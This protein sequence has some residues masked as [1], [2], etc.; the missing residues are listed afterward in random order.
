[1]SILKTILTLV[2]CVTS[3]AIKAQ[4]IN[5]D[6]SQTFSTLNLQ[7]G[8]FQVETGVQRSVLRFSPI[9]SR[10]PG[11]YVSQSSKWDIPNVALRWGLSDFL[12]LRFATQHA[13]I[14][15]TYTHPY[16]SISPMSYPWDFGNPEFGVKFKFLNLEEK[17][18]H[19]S[20]V[21]HVGLPCSE[22]NIGSDKSYF[23]Y[24]LNFSYPIGEK[25]SLAHTFQLSQIDDTEMFKFTAMYSK[26][27]TENTQLFFEFYRDIVSK[28]KG[29]T[30]SYFDLGL[31][32]R[33]TD[34]L[35]LDW[36]YGHGLN[37]SFN[38]MGIGFSSLISQ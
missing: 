8:Q 30:S 22:S 4:T 2:F 31:T 29:I 10:R 37:Q 18:I 24:A 21:M 15:D 5:T 32:H 25:S 16:D 1:M 20:M 13:N 12:E 28:G 6:P 23:F 3:F 17:N 36:Y 11:T 27:L 19:G 35:Q 34:K 14:T 26:E 7:K 33:L 38:M 9:D